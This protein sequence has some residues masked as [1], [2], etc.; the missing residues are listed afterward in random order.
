M[1]AAAALEWRDVCMLES[2]HV[3]GTQGRTANP[4]GQ[5]FFI[6]TS[7]IWSWTLVLFE[8]SFAE[9]P[10]FCLHL[11]RE[12]C[13]CLLACGWR[14]LTVNTVCACEAGRKM[15]FHFLPRRTAA[16]G[17]GPT[18]LCLLN[19]PS[20]IPSCI[21]FQTI[22]EL[23]I[24]PH[25]WPLPGPLILVA[26]GAWPPPPGWSVSQTTSTNART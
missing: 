8:R 2:P 19:P 15:F 11:G 16:C 5:Q 20:F 24:P 7:N 4:V 17:L 23:L 18:L 22:G 25:C 10:A 9:R 1:S 3:A 6:K 21:G 13:V 26:G 12:V 14:G